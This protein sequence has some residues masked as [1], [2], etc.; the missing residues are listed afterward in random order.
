LVF[1]GWFLGVGTVWFVARAATEAMV[2][3]DLWFGYLLG[4]PVFLIVVIV[5]GH[6]LR[7]IIRPFNLSLYY[8]PRSP[9]PPDDVMC[10]R[11]LTWR[12]VHDLVNSGWYWG[13]GWLLLAAAVFGLGTLVASGELTSPCDL[14]PGVNDPGGLAGASAHWILVLQ[15]FWLGLPGDILKVGAALIGESC[16]LTSS[17]LISNSLVA[18]ALVLLAYV[19]VIPGGVAFT[20]YP[21]LR[22]RAMVRA[23]LRLP[24]K[25]FAPAEI[26]TP[27]TTQAALTIVVHGTFA[28]DETWWN[29][30]D[31]AGSFA[32]RLET[33]LS[34]LGHSGTVWA[35]AD[36][37]GLEAHT[38]HWSGDNTD[39]E[40]RHGA[41]R[42]SK[43]LHENARATRASAS[44]PIPLNIVAH[45]HGG[46]VAL[47]MLKTLPDSYF[48]N[49]LVM[50]G[51]PNLGVRPSFRIGRVLI[52]ASYAF[53]L[54]LTVAAAGY[55]L[56]RVME[57]PF[58][59]DEG[60]G[61]G[62]ALVALVMLNWCVIFAALLGDMIWH[63]F[64]R[65]VAL[66]AGR[67]GPGV[68]GPSQM[69]LARRIG[70][71]RMFNLISR[72]DEASVLLRA[73][74]APGLLV[75]ESVASER[76]WFRYLF[77]RFVTEPILR[78]LILKASET[79]GEVY[80]L[81][82]SW[83]RVLF[84]D[85]DVARR[86][87]PYS[88]QLLERVDVTRQIANAARHLEATHMRLLWDPRDD[89]ELGTGHD[90]VHTFD[91]DRMTVMEF[92][93][94]QLKLL[95]SLYYEDP[96][97]TRSVAALLVDGREALVRL[98]LQDDDN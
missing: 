51:S 97:L 69:Q 71:G 76:N 15:Q 32:T 70:R 83:V 61:F 62:L 53:L 54:P 86:D 27:E 28:R 95:H 74:A 79:V 39:R 98:R 68:Y 87:F 57:G 3:L 6:W 75:K 58:I 12:S 96:I 81:G 38:F 89:E 90:M 24:F 50:L 91:Q 88:N 13:A 23:R 18:S 66:L 7:S 55:F 21:G 31:D 52:A 41:V 45:S 84:Y 33:E 35:F 26:P 8:D 94:S 60:I 93:K 4:G 29:D 19:L 37:S 77:R 64:G 49:R 9:R 14:M 78:F 10:V 73:M 16:T 59:A 85:Y 92:L 47:E 42:L 34:E 17:T 40:R 48:V 36:R 44:S 56:Y 46:N 20:L 30:M 43:L 80:A 65:V 67:L 2:G 1:Y 25:A 63:P 72:H 11:R 22:V 5:P 82:F